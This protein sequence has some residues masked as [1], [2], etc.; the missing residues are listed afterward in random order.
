MGRELGGS[1]RSSAGG[2]SEM[3]GAGAGETYEVCVKVGVEDVGWLAWREVSWLRVVG[4]RDRPCGVT[5]RVGRWLGM[6][7]WLGDV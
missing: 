4:E 6:G 2:G 1:S 3:G 5:M 7:G